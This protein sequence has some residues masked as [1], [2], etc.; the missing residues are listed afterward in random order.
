MNLVHITNH[1]LA[2][3]VQQGSTDVHQEHLRQNTG[4]ARNNCEANCGWKTNWI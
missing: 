3:P 2:H 4:V 1:R